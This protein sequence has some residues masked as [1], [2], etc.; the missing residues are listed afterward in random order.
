MLKAIQADAYRQPPKKEAPEKVGYFYTS[1]G[2]C[3]RAA[4]RRPSLLSLHSLPPSFSAVLSDR[5][6]V[7]DTLMGA[8][9]SRTKSVCVCVFQYVCQGGRSCEP[10]PPRHL[11]SGQM[12]GLYAG[13]VAGEERGHGGVAGGSGDGQGGGIRRHRSFFL[14]GESGGWGVAL[15]NTCAPAPLCPPSDALSERPELSKNRRRQTKDFVARLVQANNNRRSL[16]YS[17]I[18]VR[19]HIGPFAT[20]AMSSGWSSK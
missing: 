16:V 7:S 15:R 9:F 14:G 19:A 2:C 6:C 1:A 11:P 13:I 3:R 5:C 10:P 17:H 4:G 18:H 8:A 12:A 20:R